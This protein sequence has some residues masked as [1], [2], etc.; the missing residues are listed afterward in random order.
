[1]SFGGFTDVVTAAELGELYRSPAQGAVDK[2]VDRIDGGCRQIIDVSSLVLVATSSAD[3]RLD[4]SPRGGPAGF[5]QVIDEH[6]IALPD[7]SGNNR[8]DSIRNI[9][10]TGEIG[11]L[12][13]VPGL[14]ETLR[15]NGS[16]CITTAPDVLDGFTAELKRPKAAVG[17]EVREAFVHCAKAFR[18]GEVWVPDTWPTG[19][20]CPAIGQILVDHLG[21]VGVDGAAVDAD[22]D[23]GYRATL[24]AERA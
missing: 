21:L 8:L 20:S 3:G 11:L 7:L 17:I 19:E 13:V 24:E 23:A 18:R 10:D 2:V 14:D 15:V 4:V 6:H 12:F 5:V 9:I 1:M 16:A 22:L